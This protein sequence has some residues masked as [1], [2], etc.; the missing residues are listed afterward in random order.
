MPVYVS[1]DATGFEV[2][3]NL[4]LW[5]I[6]FFDAVAGLFISLYLLISHD[7]LEVGSIEPMELSNTIN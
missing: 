1:K 4:T 2:S 3:L 7:D 5:V 6:G